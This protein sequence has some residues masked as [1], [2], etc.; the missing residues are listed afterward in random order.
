MCY[1]SRCASPQTTW[2][3]TTKY[4]THNHAGA[5]CLGMPPDA[6]LCTTQKEPPEYTP[7]TVS[8]EAK[9]QDLVFIKGTLQRKEFLCL[10]GSFKS[11]ALLRLKKLHKEYEKEG[12]GPLSIRFEEDGSRSMWLM[13]AVGWSEMAAVP[14]SKWNLLPFCPPCNPLLTKLTSPCLVD[15]LPCLCTVCERRKADNTY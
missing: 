11:N 4:S 2:C 12:G 6:G 10:S 8:P 3:Q 5:A 9:G 15:G 14:D 7:C 1:M 13:S